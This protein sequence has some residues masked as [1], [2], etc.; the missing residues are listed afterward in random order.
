MYM[1]MATII[2]LSLFFTSVKKTKRFPL[3][4][5]ERCHH[6]ILFPMGFLNA[7][8]SPLQTIFHRYATPSIIIC[9]NR[10]QLSHA[11]IMYFKRRFSAISRASRSKTIRDG[12]SYPYGS[13][14]NMSREIRLER[15]V[16]TR[17]SGDCNGVLLR[18]SWSR[19]Y[20]FYPER[21]SSYFLNLNMNARGR[22]PLDG[23]CWH[24]GRACRGTIDLFLTSWLVKCQSQQFWRSQS[25]LR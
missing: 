5:L 9:A 11:Y 20:E 23:D 3:Y 25:T 8:L 7:L 22:L 10:S 24:K 19:V 4:C 6:F 17:L 18:K 2:L 13:E 12:A 16:A 21:K 14:S 15:K 1:K